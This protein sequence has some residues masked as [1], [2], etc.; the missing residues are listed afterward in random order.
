[1]A[2]RDFDTERAGKT[3]ETE[4]PQDATRSNTES[5]RAGGTLT[6]EDLHTHAG[7]GSAT[8]S[9][10]GGVAPGKGKPGKG[11]KVLLIAFAILAFV[12]I[13]FGYLMFFSKP[14][15][16]A[17]RPMPAT[18]ASVTPAKPVSSAATGN[19]FAASRPE[20]PAGHPAPAIAPTVA[21]TT[22]AQ[23]G[24]ASNPF[25]AT[26]PSSV[27]MTSA[28]SA[29]APQATVPAAP[30][31]APPASAPPASLPSAFAPQHAP[32]VTLPVAS[33]A[34]EL[35]ATA[36]NPVSSAPGNIPATPAPVAPATP[37]SLAPPAASATPVEPP[38]PAP[39][40]EG[41]LSGIRTSIATLQAGHDALQAQ[42]ST[43][44]ERLDASSPK[45]TRAADETA[46]QGAMFAGKPAASSTRHTR[47]VRHHRSSKDENMVERVPEK[48]AT[49]VSSKSISSASDA[50][51][52]SVSC[53]LAAIVPDRAWVKNADG[54]FTTYG[55]GDLAPNGASI[56]AISPG[57]GITTKKGHLACIQ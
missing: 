3:G 1:M 40:I 39:G 4:L 5:T 55:V 35:P 56:T 6:G 33:G 37:A 10:T 38:A 29:F 44:Q 14:H 24:A 48:P 42:V 7:T 49:M 51:A 32:E 30:A 50:A 43:I 36:P 28:P 31:S 25:G 17:R 21:P 57:A 34:A 26:P 46:S 19:P 23:P 2:S 22:P 12:V 15:A 11:N 8:R 27:P 45:R 53:H 47:R 13:V 41:E 9:A 54:T 16:T 52:P 20:A 18:H